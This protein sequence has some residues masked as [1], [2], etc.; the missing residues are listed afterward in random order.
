MTN[1]PEEQSWVRGRGA[2]SH[3]AS[4]LSLYPLSSSRCVSLEQVGHLG[5]PSQTPGQAGLVSVATLRPPVAPGIAAPAPLPQNPKRRR[6]GKRDGEGQRARLL[7]WEDLEVLIPNRELILWRE[8]GLTS[9]S[10]YLQPRISN[11]LN[12]SK[13]KFLYLQSGVSKIHL[14]IKVK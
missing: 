9:Q 6:E 1:C 11:Y 8:H 2:R 10:L 4:S 7:A 14:L 12:L 13:P 3:R 5:S